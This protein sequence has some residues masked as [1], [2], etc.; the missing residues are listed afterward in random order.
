MTELAHAWRLAQ[1][2]VSLVISGATAPAQVHANACAAAWVL[3]ADE[4]AEV[5]TP[6][7]QRRNA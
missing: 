7:L 2:Q 5:H 6:P 3:T 4:L 1:P